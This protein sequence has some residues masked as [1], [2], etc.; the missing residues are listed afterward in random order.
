MSES[1]VYSPVAA[2]AGAPFRLVRTGLS[3]LARRI[4][5]EVRQASERRVAASVAAANHPGVA[6]DFERA[7]RRR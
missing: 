3:R 2:T 6:A 4:S 7:C 5:D 1:A